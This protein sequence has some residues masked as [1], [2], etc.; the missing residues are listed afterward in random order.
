MYEGVKRGLKK[1]L[2]TNALVECYV[3]FT[4]LSINP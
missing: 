2:L 4:I 1:P 3:Y